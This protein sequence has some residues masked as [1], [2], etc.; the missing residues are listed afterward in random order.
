LQIHSDVFSWHLEASTVGDPFSA[1]RVFGSVRVD[2]D[3]PVEIA[4]CLK[5]PSII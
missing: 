3:D 4:A 2:P 5:C 1:D